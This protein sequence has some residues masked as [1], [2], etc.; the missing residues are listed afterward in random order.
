MLTC[1]RRL[2]RDVRE[3]GK[4]SVRNAKAEE[5]RTTAGIALKKKNGDMF[6]VPDVMVQAL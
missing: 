3:K 2:V 6:H 1:Q 5:G 4:R